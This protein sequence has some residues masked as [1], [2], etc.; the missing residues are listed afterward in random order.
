MNSNVP[1]AAPSSYVVVVV[2]AK[3]VVGVPQAVGAMVGVLVVVL[4]VV[5]LVVVVL[6]VVVLVVVVVGTSVVVVDVV[7]VV[8]V[9]VLGV[10][11]PHGV[12]VVLDV[13]IDWQ[14]RPP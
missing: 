8:V 14:A 13:C 5:E 6:V 10:A 4:V 1:L 7:D 3:P 11:R 9:L 12:A 2:P